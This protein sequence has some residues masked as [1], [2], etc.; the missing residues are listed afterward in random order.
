MEQT[1]EFC[2][3]MVAVMTTTMRTAAMT[4]TR[5]TERRTVRMGADGSMAI[6]GTAAPASIRVRLP[7]PA[8]TS[9]TRP[10]RASIAAVTSQATASAE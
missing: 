1:G 3:A 9:A 4:G 2:A 5:V 6:T 7:V 10:S 8:A